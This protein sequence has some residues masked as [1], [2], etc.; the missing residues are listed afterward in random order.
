MNQSSEKI[1][2]ELDEYREK[3]IA[4]DKEMIYRN[5]INI[6]FAEGTAFYA[7]QLAEADEALDALVVVD[8]KTLDAC[9]DYVIDGARKVCDEMGADLPTEDFHKLIWDYFQMPIDVASI[10]IEKAAEKRKQEAANRTAEYQA[11]TLKRKEAQKGAGMMQ[12]SL[13]E[14]MDEK[15]EKMD[16]D[17]QMSLFD[18]PSVEEKKEE[19]QQV[20]LFN[21]P[22]M[23]NEQEGD[24]DEKIT[25]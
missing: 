5:A 19:D 25:A 15:S 24:S 17:P 7:T 18:A 8:G 21:L 16:D 11:N 14:M 1:K 9:K 3:M 12:V 6:I 22:G 2:N 20:S 13:F 4:M 23:T 10:A